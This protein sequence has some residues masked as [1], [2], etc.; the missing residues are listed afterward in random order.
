MSWRMDMDL[1][2]NNELQRYARFAIRSTAEITALRV[3]NIEV[4]NHRISCHNTNSV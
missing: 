1:E 3:Q 4:T 2:A